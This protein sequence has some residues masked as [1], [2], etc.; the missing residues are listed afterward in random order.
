MRTRPIFYL[1]AL[2]LW[3]MPVP[4]PVAWGGTAAT[5]PEGSYRNP[6]GVDL[7]DPHVLLHDGVYYAYGTSAADGFKV[8]S[9]SNL[10][11]WEGHGYA[12][13][14]T[15]DTWGNDLFWAPC[16]IAHRGAF[17]LFYSSRGPVEGDRQSHRISVAR[18][19]SPLGPFVDVAAPLFDHGMAVIDAHALIDEDGAAYLYFVRDISESGKSRV[20]AARLA[21]DL[22]SLTGEPV[23]CIEPSQPWEGE[24]WNEAPFV[25]RHGDTYVMTYSANGFYDPRYA[26]GYATAPSPLGPWTK[27]EDNP[28]LQRTDGVSGPGHNSMVLSPD[29]SEWFAVYHVH[30]SL[31]GGHRR[32]LAIDRMTIEEQPDGSLRLRIDGPTSDPQPLPSGAPAAH[33]EPALAP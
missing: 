32:E 23:L 14:R 8:W 30:K 11:D 3:F 22:L 26:V 6:L 2:L 7:A 24:Q 12:L 28:I 29:G 4:V 19:E 31:K 18:A 13:Q 1:L 17:Y 15:A 20:W 33:A 9:S 25:I 10:V 16:V 21:D 5:P 27:A